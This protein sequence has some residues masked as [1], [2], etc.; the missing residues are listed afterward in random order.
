MLQNANWDIYC[1]G[2]PQG[3]AVTSDNSVGLGNQAIAQQWETV[4]MASVESSFPG[5][6]M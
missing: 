5:N 1:D 3:I 6:R 2:F 4:P